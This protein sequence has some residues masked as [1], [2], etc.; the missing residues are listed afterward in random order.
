[1]T[2]IDTFVILCRDI[3]Q[4]FS[5]DLFFTAF[6]TVYEAVQQGFLILHLSSSSC[7]KSLWVS[8]SPMSSGSTTNDWHKYH[9]YILI[10]KKTNTNDVPQE[11]CNFKQTQQLGNCIQTEVKQVC[12][13]LFWCVAII[14]ISTERWAVSS[15][16]KLPPSRNSV[17][18]N[19]KPQYVLHKPSQKTHRENAIWSRGHNL[20]RS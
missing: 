1:M 9:I 5:L 15:S 16:L 11:K 7:I 19:F 10:S 3:K 20:C 18:L 17:A 13:P 8:L 12:S 4:N 2:A 6:G 14:F